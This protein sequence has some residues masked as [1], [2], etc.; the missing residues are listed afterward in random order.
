[1]TNAR[2]VPVRLRVGRRDAPYVLTKPLHASQQVVERFP[3]RSVEIE[4]RV[5]HNYELERLLLGFGD[6]LEVLAPKRLRKRMRNIFKSGA[7][8]Y[9]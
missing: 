6:G 1:M 7:A 9:G 5:Q 3:D 4:L 2:P 8:L